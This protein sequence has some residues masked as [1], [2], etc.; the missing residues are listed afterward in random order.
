MDPK[1]NVFTSCFFFPFEEHG[2][3][4]LAADGEAIFRNFEVRGS[5]GRQG[6]IG[7][8]TSSRGF[9]TKMAKKTQ[10][11][12]RYFRLPKTPT[13]HGFS[14]V[15]IRCEKNFGGEEV[16][17]EP[18]STLPTSPFST[19]PRRS[20]IQEKVGSLQRSWMSPRK[21]RR[22]EGADGFPRRWWSVVKNVVG[23]SVCC[24]VC[25]RSIGFWSKGRVV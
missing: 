9:L 16:N 22:G 6:G 11:G 13:I 12:K 14:G 7:S 17:R 18:K 4:M 2:D 15:F 21:K 1:H 10:K 8:S 20:D 24:C 23:W 5:P 19:A 25:L 3:D